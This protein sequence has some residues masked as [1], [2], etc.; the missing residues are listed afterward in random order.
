MTPAYF[1]TVSVEDEFLGFN[2]LVG[3][4]RRRNLALESVALGTGH[5]P[6]MARVTIALRADEAAVDRLV[7][8]LRKMIGVRDAVAVPEAEAL[9]REIALIK[10]RASGAHYAEVLDAAARFGASV[11]E[12][13]HQAV[14]LEATGTGPMLLCLIRALEPYGVLEVA[15]SGTVA[16][17]RAE[18]AGSNPAPA[19][20]P[21]VSGR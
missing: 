15:R 19:A 10:V 8:Q 20:V 1:I 6:G 11:L 5:A 17:G 14:V 4:V 12:E 16:V 13:G 7:R 18:P 2:R 3:I 9:D 21:V